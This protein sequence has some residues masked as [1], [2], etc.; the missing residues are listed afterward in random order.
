MTKLI[1]ISIKVPTQRDAYL[2]KQIAEHLR[3][4]ASEQRAT[5]GNKKPKKQMS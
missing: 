2:I 1:T 4:S 5:R 3:R